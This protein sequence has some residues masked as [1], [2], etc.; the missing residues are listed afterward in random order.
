MDEE[1][2]KEEK[3]YIFPKFTLLYIDNGITYVTW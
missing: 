1:K 3:N 2:T